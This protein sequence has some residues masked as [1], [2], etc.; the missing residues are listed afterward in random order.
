M[1]ESVFLYM[2]W[3]GMDA[4]HDVK[5]DDDDELQKKVVLVVVAA[6]KKKKKKER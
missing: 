5:L 4:V 1:E 2:A 6:A 3:H